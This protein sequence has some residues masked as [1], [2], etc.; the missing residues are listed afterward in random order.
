LRARRFAGFTLAIAIGVLTPRSSP[1]Q[2]SRATL[3]SAELWFDAKAS[4]GPFRGVTHTATGEMTGGPSAL[5]MVRG[6]VESPSASL[7]TDNSIR[8][9]DMRKTLEVEKFPAIRFD[10]DSVVVLS[11][12]TDSARVELLGRLTVHGVSKHIRFP[13]QVRLEKTQARVTGGFDMVLPEYKIT[14]L[15]RMLGAL[16]MQETIKVGLDVTFTIVR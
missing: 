5:A 6:F 3:K 13:A 11:E 2:T 12:T 15:K 8:D 9:H 1:A 7:S 14:N 10:L 16:T 4:L